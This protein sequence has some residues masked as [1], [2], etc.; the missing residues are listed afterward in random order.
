MHSTLMRPAKRAARLMVLAAWMATISYWSGQGNLAI[1][2]PIVAN[3]LHG[4]QHRVAHLVAFGGLGLLAGWAF[5]G[6]PRAALWAVVLTAVFGATDE[7]HQSFTPGRRAALDDWAMD[8]ASAAMA[9]Y[10]WWRI[11]TTRWHAYLRPVAPLAIGGLFVV[12]VGLALLP[13]GPLC[14]DAKGPALHSVMTRLTH[15]AA[16]VAARSSTSSR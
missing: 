6:I 7:W 5:S 12:G 15:Y 10:A 4:L 13:A 3:L 14:C 1:D 8:T 2:Q 16:T 11:R 9:V